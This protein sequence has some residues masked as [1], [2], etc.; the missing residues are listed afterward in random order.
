M[1]EKKPPDL[2]R[3]LLGTPWASRRRYPIPSRRRARSAKR[4]RVKNARVDLRVHRVITM[5]KMNQAC[6]FVSIR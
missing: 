4:K 5:V 1:I 2:H 6:K 3:G